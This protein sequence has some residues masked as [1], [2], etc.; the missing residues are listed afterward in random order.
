MRDRVRKAFTN[1]CQRLAWWLTP[2]KANKEGAQRSAPVADLETAGKAGKSEL[3]LKI[4]PYRG[5][6]RETKCRSAATESVARAC[7]FK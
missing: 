3:F 1:L 7:V 5:R 4:F 2:L 6:S